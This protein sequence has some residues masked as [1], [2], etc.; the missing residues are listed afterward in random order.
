MSKRLSWVIL[1]IIF[2]A[3]TF[4]KI[5]KI[6]YY[7]DDECFFKKDG[8]FYYRYS[9]AIF[10]NNGIPAVDKEISFPSGYKVKNNKALFIPALTGQLNSLFPVIKHHKFIILLFSLFTS[11]TIFPLFAMLNLMNKKYL[12]NLILVVLFTTTPV[13]SKHIINL[14]P[15]PFILLLPVIVLQIFLYLKGINERRKKWEIIY[16]FLSGCLFYLV[17]FS[18]TFS[19]IYIFLFSLT[20]IIMMIIN[21][22]R[23][24][25][26]FPIIGGFILLAG[27]ISPHLQIK[28]YFTSIPVLLIYSG[29]IMSFFKDKRKW[30][31]TFTPLILIFI[32]LILRINNILEGEYIVENMLKISLIKF[33]YY[34][35][36]LSPENIIW[37][38]L[39]IWNRFFPSPDFITTMKSFGALLPAG[40][41]SIVTG[42][43]RWKKFKNSREKKFM[44]ILTVLTVIHFLIIKDIGIL[45]A[46]FLAFSIYFIID[47]Y[48]R[49]TIYVLLF[50]FLPN[51]L[52]LYSYG[53][54]ENLTE[55]NYTL[56]VTKF[57]RHRTEENTSVLT[58]VKHSPIFLTC[59]DRPITLNPFTIKK[60]A[61]NKIKVFEYSIYHSEKEF[62]K[63][64]SKHKV[65]Y[66]VYNK[67]ILL[68]LGFASM[69]V[70]TKNKFLSKTSPAFLFHF[71]PESLNEFIL[72]FS[73]PQYRIY[74][75]RYTDIQSAKIR[76]EYMRTY[77]TDYYNLKKLGIR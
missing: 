37:K 73:N 55:K 70:R 56:Q 22:D 69:R 43:Y 26:A 7:P 34:F 31:F 3:I 25:P 50:L 18:W 21:H 15:E 1:C 14:N 51:I 48:R 54:Q 35:K 2:I 64:C 36:I 28:T 52:L 6:K 41:F 9:K 8:M 77:D 68:S 38:D 33:G 75:V 53:T 24:Y 74:Q 39:Y 32:Y 57:L 47:F 63:F 72:I 59:S 60:G 29:I 45:L 71:E 40:L 76:L 49:K 62:Y 19:H 10:N 4:F 67:N 16:Y 17:I 12:Y 58:T 5:H 23:N 30:I 66:F 27:F 65:R 11:L 46:V 13:F 42:F 61:L 44:L 20:S